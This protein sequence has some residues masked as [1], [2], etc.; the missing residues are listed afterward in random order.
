[1]SLQ[2]QLRPEITHF[3]ACDSTNQLLL[4]A[5]ETGAAPGSVFVAYQQRAG[6][7]RRGRQWLATPGHS[8]TCSILWTFPDEPLR[9][10]GLPL[11]VGL[12]LV[13]A[14]A[15]PRLGTRQS[16]VRCGLKWPNDLL[17]Q[18]ANGGYA[19]LGG[20][21]VESVWRTAVGGEKELAVVIG[22]GLNCR[23]DPALQPAITGQ[24]VA[25]VSELLVTPR[26]PDDILPIVL[27]QL[28]PMLSLFAAQG[29]TPF[30]DAWNDHDL[31]RHQQVV[32]TEEGLVRL[33]GKSLGVDASGTLYLETSLGLKQAVSGDVSLRGA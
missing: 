32:I 33:A 22:I 21:L 1:M 6:R 27:D 19:K 9:L 29:F 5:A 20:I 30:M 25:A 11:L 17:L 8:L 18:Y 14:L 16:T 28:F 26:G 10:Q 31:W 4:A 12:A 7:G 13:Q 15:D 2:K 24:P 23:T 3:D